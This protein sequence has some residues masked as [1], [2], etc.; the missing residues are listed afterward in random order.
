[1]TETFTV[2]LAPSFPTVAV[3]SF[4]FMA[5]ILIIGFS[6]KM[7]HYACRLPRTAA[8]CLRKCATPTKVAPFDVSRLQLRLRLRQR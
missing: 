3:A 4:V 5:L 6:I 2:E 1:V 7:F 8:N